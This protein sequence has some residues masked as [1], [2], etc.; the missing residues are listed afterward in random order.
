MT[1]VSRTPRPRKP[2]GRTLFYNVKAGAL[3]LT[4]NGKEFAYWLD[5][6]AHDF[7]AAVRCVRLTKF[8]A[9]RKAGEPDAYDVTVSADGT[10]T[11]ECLGFLR[12][13][14]CKHADALAVLLT[15]G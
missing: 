8:V 12:H 6:L 3:F 10:R 1:T 13:S 14:H 7:G 4:I 9:N 15:R 11:C 2:V 5:R